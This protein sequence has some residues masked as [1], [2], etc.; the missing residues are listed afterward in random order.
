MNALVPHIFEG[1]VVEG[2]FLEPN[3]FK[4]GSLNFVEADTT[5]WSLGDYARDALC[6]LPPGYADHLDLWI[7]EER[8]DPAYWEHVKPKAGRTV[9]VRVRPRG[10][11]AKNI[12]R[13]V[14][15][16]AIIA[17][18]TYFLGPAG[19]FVTGTLGLTGAAAAAVGAALVATATMIGMLAVNA[20]IP[21]PG[22]TGAGDKDPRY[23]LTGSS[24]RYAPYAPIPRPFGKIR[25]YPVVAGHPYTEMVGKKQYLRMLLCFGWGP[26]KISDIRIGN[27]P[28]SAFRNVE[29][30]VHEGGPAG[31]AGNKTIRLYNRRVTETQTNRELT[32]LSVSASERTDP[33]T[34]T[35][36]LDVSF[37]FGLLEIEGDGDRD[38]QW[39]DFRVEYRAAGSGGAWIKPSLIADSDVDIRGTGEFR[40]TGRT[41][42]A[43]VETVRFNVTQGQY[44]VRM[45][46]LSQT[47][48]DGSGNGKVELDRSYWTVMRSF[49]TDKP[50][51][52]DG[53]CLLALRMQATDQLNGVPQQISALVE[54][55]LPDWNGTSYSLTRSPARAFA[56]ILRRRAGIPYI[57]DSRIDI[58]T[59]QSWDADCA[60]TA[61]N[62][63]EAKWNFDGVIEGGSVYEAL[64]K[65]AAAGRAAYT[66]KDGKFSVVRDK[67]QPVPVQVITP[68]NS[69]DYRG[70]RS[71][72]DLPHA[73]RV[74]FQNAAADYRMDERLVF[75]D[76]Y[77]ETNATKYEAMPALGATSETQAWREG[78]YH[79]A[80]GYLRPEEH[81]VSMDIEGLRCSLGDRVQLAHDV[82]VVGQTQ[83]R[84]V[85]A[86]GTQVE[87][88]EEV[89]IELGKTY[90]LRVRHQ[91]GTQTVRTV[92]GE[93][94]IGFWHIVL[95]NFADGLTKPGDLFLFGESGLE[96]AP[97]IVKRIE[98]GDELSVVITM[99][100]YDDAIYTSDTAP[101]PPFLSYLEAYI[102]NLPPGTPGVALRSDETVRAI[103]QGNAVVGRIAV[104]ITPP[105]YSR[106]PLEGFDVMYREVGSQFW[107][108]TGPLWPVGLPTVF[109]NG[110]VGS[111]YEVQVR[112]KA[113]NGLYSDWVQAGP[114]TVQAT[115]FPV[116]PPTL[117]SA[118][119]GYRENYI[120]WTNPPS[121]SFAYVEIYASTTNN[122]L[123]A[124]LVGFSAAGT[125]THTGLAPNILYY[126]WGRTVDSSGATSSFVA[127]GSA[128]ALSIALYEGIGSDSVL[129]PQEKLL[130][131]REFTQLTAEK[132]G[133]E[134]QATNLGITTEKT[135]YLLA[136]TTLSNYLTGLS[137]GYTNTSASTTINRTVWNQNW[138]AVYSTRQALLN[139]ID[140]LSSTTASTS[141]NELLNDTFDRNYWLYNLS[142][143]DPWM[144]R[145]ARNANDGFH[146][147]YSAFAME[148]NTPVG[149]NNNRQAASQ[150]PMTVVPGKPYYAGVWVQKNAGVPNNAFLTYGMQFYD[151]AG[152]SI[153]P[154]IWLKD[155]VATELVAGTPP[156]FFSQ[157]FFAPANA[158][159]GILVIYSNLH[160][161]GGGK[162]RTE[163]PLLSFT[164]PGAD[165]TANITGPAAADVY[166]DYLGT[167]FQSAED[168]DY[169]VQVG[170]TGTVPSDIDWSYKVLS[171][172]FNGR[173]GL[174]GALAMPNT[175][176]V[177]TITPTSM[178][179][180]TAILEITAVYNERL[181]PAFQT[182]VTKKKAA[183]PQPG[184]GG[185][186][187][188]ASQSS[189]FTKITTGTFTTITQSLKFTLP[190][191]KTTL[192]ALVQLSCRMQP[193]TVNET[194]GWDVEF[195][196]MRGGVAQGAVQHSN[197]DPYI[198]Y[199]DD[200]GL[201]FS[202]PGQM[203]YLL[204]MTG[205]TAG[206]QYT[207][208]VEA[209][210]ASGAIPTSPSTYGIGFTGEVTL[211]AP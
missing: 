25:M 76:G 106:T 167:T 139:R 24:N 185:G 42:D 177:G 188:L 189:G 23:Q 66:M 164:E 163:R 103:L 28:L 47:G 110:K 29:Y 38:E 135:A 1:D 40:V 37:P 85:S 10:K 41:N 59:L 9:Y 11:G 31:W 204:D 209:R 138:S 205:L 142:D 7:E 192:R 114:I 127:F 158:A 54:T 159:T 53:V 187:D 12:L 143:S 129:H 200:A 22:L 95:G 71:F 39:V 210:I 61:A 35:I 196:V 74:E 161:T 20:L 6:V 92:T 146:V 198:D 140:A 173:T 132:P 109:I 4:V 113:L 107:T 2:Y 101:I 115:T 80:V 72:V 62:A 195:R 202:S 97:M 45:T 86:S 73:L 108:S 17:A 32:Y 203:Y 68:K 197:P 82:M 157:A 48:A 83:G 5:G 175:S 36:A 122:V 100:N 15:M 123:T 78:R 79:L 75:M 137:P 105:G 63:A 144:R 50:V 34:V 171:G 207:V 96:S 169:R 186:T 90:Q 170:G 154:I 104:D 89:H 168:L 98:P 69:W 119:A 148:W 121:P 191:G 174:N 136:Y 193:K 124:I 151:A 30:E 116:Q 152:A 165:I 8:I 194:G 111:P 126:Y 14:V 94:G 178:E 64:R 87:L 211:S 190:S 206:T 166:Y 117:P 145:V 81:S 208:T 112:C 183:A 120:R 130:V 153:F 3:P 201:L 102:D 26:L 58:A 77:D 51:V 182:A 155:I 150:P 56:D 70:A 21:A 44:D 176:G 49:T 65:V 88:D 52:Q 131:I 57:S 133:L 118:T 199:S 141:V 46:R 13:V 172:K 43:V 99:T 128:T 55:Y 179:T 19:G 18:A 162:W 156:K 125:F 33:N 60:A 27:T 180:D 91:N 149:A 160:G 93:F 84:I 134:T 181:L 147:G 67:S 16:I 184:G